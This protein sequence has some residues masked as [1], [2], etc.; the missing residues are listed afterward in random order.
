M[1][2]TTYLRFM[3]QDYM[4]NGITN[5]F[6]DVMSKNAV[7]D[8]APNTKMELGKRKK[9][10]KEKKENVVMAETLPGHMG[11]LS[12]EQLVHLIEGSHSE[13]QNKEKKQGHKDKSSS[14]VVENLTEETSSQQTKKERRRKSKELKENTAPP[15][16]PNAVTIGAQ[17]TKTGGSAATAA[18]TAITA[19]SPVAP[20]TSQS[21]KMEFTVANKRVTSPISEKRRG[22]GSGAERTVRCSTEDGEEEFLSA[23]EGVASSIE[24]PGL[25][26]TVPA[27]SATTTNTTTTTS[28][29]SSASEVVLDG[30]NYRA[31]DEDVTQIERQFADEQEFITVNTKKKK[32]AESS[33][34]QQQQRTGSAGKDDRHQR[35][36]ERL[37]PAR[38]SSLGVAPE[39]RVTPAQNSPLPSGRR[40][41]TASLGDF[42]DGKDV[43]KIQTKPFSAPNAPKNVKKFQRNERH[44]QPDVEV[45]LPELPVEQRMSKPATQSVTCDSPERTFSYA[46]AA[47]KSSEP[48]RD[49]SPACVAV[50]SPSAKS[51]SPAPQ[52]PTPVAATVQENSAADVLSCADVPAGG[53]GAAGGLSF[54]YDESEAAQYE[55]AEGNAESEPAPDSAFVLNLGGKTVRFAKGM[56][57]PAADTP[58]TNSHHMCMVEMLAQRW[59]MFQEGHV[60]QIYQP[61]IASS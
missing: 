50:A 41:T 20:A 25:P 10:K 33:T 42:L 59:K 51:D 9:G 60:P 28:A 58:P 26:R 56:A 57:S 39:A 48:S 32:A 61:R 5:N 19:S 31:D 15:S 55:G 44:S 35:V 49:N 23:D 1:I 13:Q 3:L 46:D 11:Q 53:S 22:K 43:P 36:A 52:T 16:A 34:K 38:R 14:V 2:D 37:E 24:E 47:K 40:P 27:T 54:F 18:A 21:P 8:V 17:Q 4:S 7:H 6:E 29:V 30:R 45:P 12:V